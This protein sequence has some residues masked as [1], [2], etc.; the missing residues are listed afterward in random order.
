MAIAQGKQ[1]TFNG[2]HKNAGWYSC[3]AQN[4]HGKQSAEI[5][6]T[7]EGEFTVKNK[8]IYRSKAMKIT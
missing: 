6:L 1:V 2:T 8:V 3:T 7:V 5:Q 4:K